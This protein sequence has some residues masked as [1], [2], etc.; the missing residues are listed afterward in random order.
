VR[1][2]AY[3]TGMRSRHLVGRAA[4]VRLAALVLCLCPAAPPLGAADWPQWG[5]TPQHAGSAPA[6]GHP[7]DSILAEV[8]YDPFV[9]QKKSE[10]SDDLLAHY[11]VPLV[12]GDAVYMTFESGAYT[13]F[14]NWSSEVWQVRKLRWSGGGLETAW[15][16]STDWQPLP[17][18]MT[19]WQSVFLPALSDAGVW[20][21]GAGG[22]VHLVSKESGAL[23]Q[24]YNPFAS[25]QASRYLV[26]GIAVAPDGGVLY[27]ALGLGPGG[28]TDDPSEA[29]LVRISASGVV[30][31][32]DYS[33]LTPGAPSATDL[34]KTRFDPD[35]RPWPPSPDAVP[36]T[37]FCGPQRPAVNAV[38]AV[39][40]D[41]TI[42]TVRRAHRVGNY[43]YL[44]AVHPDL[45]PAWSSSL[46][47][48]V[49][50]G[51]GVLLPKD[52][53]VNHCRSNAPAGVDPSTND[54]PA[55]NVSDQGTASPVV[56]PDGSVLIG[57][58]AGYNYGRGHLF[59]FDSGGDFLSS[60]DFGWDITPA[61]REHGG[62]W[63]ILIKDNHYNTNSGVPFYDVT[64]LD[65]NL[66]PEWSFRAV[67]TQSCA[68]D[69]SGTISCV[70]DH[71]DGFEWC[72]NQPVV[73]AHGTLYLNSED[74]N[75]YAFSPDGQEVGRIFLDTALGAAYTPVSMGPDGVIYAQ[76][77]GTLFAVGVPRADRVAPERVSPGPRA[78]R[79]LSPR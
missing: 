46:R 51:C 7:L 17:L 27:N 40:P 62:T 56:L 74:G 28:P 41:G 25:V 38:P 73:D 44:V 23:L 42:Y 58:Q 10:R 52:D 68:R 50:D 78:T 66:V 20:V 70:D 54:L 57:T 37:I 59:R 19:A 24:T 15:T 67:N 30:S 53:V 2:R 77:N 47:G 55:G 49:A 64:S 65:A 13:G 76:N 60:Y 75:L 4:A 18:T 72:V 36:P 21:P 12:E 45:T 29:W 63:S 14:G 6:V 35:Q 26:S 3:D 39:A 61:L 1:R 31:H 79:V 5:R 71:P 16:F 8:V 69:A 43:G 32:A 34:C 22:T 48:L 11:A 9:E 33:A